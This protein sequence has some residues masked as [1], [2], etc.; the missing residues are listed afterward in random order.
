MLEDRRHMKAR[1]L[2][3]DVMTMVPELL[4]ARAVARAQ[5]E[6]LVST[7]LKL[8]VW[9]TLKRSVGASAVS[10]DNG[11]QRVVEL[12]VFQDLDAIYLP[13]VE[14]VKAQA[15]AAKR[16]NA[17]YAHLWEGVV[18]METQYPERLMRQYQAELT[19]QVRPD[20]AVYVYIVC[21]CAIVQL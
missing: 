7:G 4:A 17:G 18:M 11:R 5:A 19:F 21:E 20:E 13:F 6:T 10:T 8:G 2:K 14:Q 15:A 9:P 12:E 16:L 1:M 3:Y